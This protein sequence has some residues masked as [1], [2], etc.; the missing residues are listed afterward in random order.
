MS[1][2]ADSL[3]HVVDKRIGYELGFLISGS[4]VVLDLLEGVGSEMS[5]HAALA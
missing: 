2:A 5:H 4:H 1:L 3:G